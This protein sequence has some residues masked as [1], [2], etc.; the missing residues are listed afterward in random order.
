MKSLI[1]EK[2]VKECRE[3]GL[4]APDSGYHSSIQASF[5]AQRDDLE[6]KGLVT[7]IKEAKE[8]LSLDFLHA[9]RP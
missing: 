5:L 1:E 4:H 2:L 7:Q 6:H 9:E 8:S 3:E